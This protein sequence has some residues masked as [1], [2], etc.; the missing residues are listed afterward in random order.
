MKLIKN[1]GKL[2][3]IHDRVLYIMNQL[4]YDKKTFARKIGV[5]ESALTSVIDR[6][7]DPSFKMIRNICSIFP[8]SEEWIF[9]GMENPFTTPDIKAFQA[10]QEV[11]N[12]H[13]N[14]DIGINTRVKQVREEAGMSQAVFAGYLS[15]SRDVITAMETLRTS[16]SATVLKR[17]VLKFNINPVWILMGEG[18]K[19]RNQK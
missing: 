14:V 15:I 8:V 5:M 12:D 10:D 11:G 18:S 4:H 17:I 3:N 7:R 16:P 2:E 13:R 19:K 1:T 6:K 9:L